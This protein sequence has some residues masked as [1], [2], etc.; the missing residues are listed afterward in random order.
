MSMR[1]NEKTASTTIN[2]DSKALH[3]IV[4]LSIK[5]TI[6]LGDCK[7]LSIKHA[8]RFGTNEKTPSLFGACSFPIVRI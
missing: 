1:A 7:D 5:G 3:N 4:D 2:N 8:I 6:R